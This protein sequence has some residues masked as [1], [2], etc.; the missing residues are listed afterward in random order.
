MSLQTNPKVEFFFTKAKNWQECAEKLRFIILECGLTE[1]LKWGVPC[2]TLNGTNV[3]LIHHFKEYIALLYHKG[4]LLADPEKI[5]IQQTEN[6]QSA[7]QLRFSNLQEITDLEATI[8]AYTFEAIEVEKAGIKVPMKKT[9]EFTVVEEFQAKLDEMSALKAAFEALTPGR[10][11][12]YLLYFAS[13]K[14]AKTRIDRIDKYIPQILIGKG[15]E[16]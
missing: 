6:V 1:E 8:K 15:L 3:V 10:Q 14:L 7:R 16:D 2:Y 12:G 5:L 13:A 9:T 11:R 4:V